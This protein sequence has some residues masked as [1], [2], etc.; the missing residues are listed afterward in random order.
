MIKK[1]VKS[2]LSV[3][4]IDF[5]QQTA[6]GAPVCWSKYTTTTVGSDIELTMY[7]NVGLVKQVILSF[8]SPRF[9]G[10]PFKYILTL[11]FR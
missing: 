7:S 5:D 11:Q 1:D 2:C 9:C 6:C 4:K 10:A 3:K 8:L